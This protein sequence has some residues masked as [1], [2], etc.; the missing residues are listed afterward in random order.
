MKILLTNDDGYNSI[1][2]KILFEKLKKYGE[3]TLIAPEEAMSGKSVSITFGRSVRV[4]EIEPNVFAMEGT[5][6]DCVAFGLSSLNKKFDL[7]ISGIN[8]GLNVSF[9]TLYSGTIGACLEALTYRVPAIAF[10]TNIGNFDVASKNIE[11][12]LDYVLDNKLLSK[13]YLLNVNFPNGNDVK[14]IKMTKLHYRKENMDLLIFFALDEAKPSICSSHL[15]HNEPKDLKYAKVPSPNF[16]TKYHHNLSGPTLW[17][18]LNP[19]F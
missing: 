6:A 19:S 13:E 10:S 17:P 11:V 3:V 8:D 5:P 18:A 12:V 9:D 2:I 1:G 15:Y 7:V 16:L 14:G 4:N